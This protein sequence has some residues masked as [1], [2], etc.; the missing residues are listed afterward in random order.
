MK[1]LKEAAIFN[2]FEIIVEAAENGKKRYYIQGIFME[3]DILNKNGRVYPRAVL[4]KEIARYKE[5]H[6]KPK[7]S[8]GEL[9]HPPTIY[10]DPER[11]SH[12]ITDLWMEGSK[13]MGRALV[14]QTP[15]GK[16][17]ESLLEDGVQL[18]VSSRGLG[19]I[20]D[21][22]AMGKLV[23]DFKL[24]TV[25]VVSDPS[26][27]N[28]FVESLFENVEYEFD[29]DGNI[30]EKQ[31]QVVLEEVK[32]V[33]VEEEQQTVQ[34]DEKIKLDEEKLLNTLIEFTKVL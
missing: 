24:V 10:V 23:E 16:I 22:G 5:T 12:L 21:K 6:I 15:L 3:A 32:E 18:G 29:K 30:V 8:M 27:P 25:D 19:K 26:A 1:F 33:L 2:P 7:R 4:E 20:I 17:V 9:N 14:L 28:A 13:V 31:K 11:S 34:L